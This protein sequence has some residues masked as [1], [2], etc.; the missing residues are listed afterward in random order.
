MP[1]HH[2]SHS[3]H[4]SQTA[5]TLTAKPCVAN[6]N[7]PN[8]ANQICQLQTHSGTSSSGTVKL[9]DM[10]CQAAAPQSRRMSCDMMLAQEKQYQYTQFGNAL[11][12]IH[13]ASW[14]KDISGRLPI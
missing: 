2:A 8:L 12:R 5:E 6:P 11:G 13:E 14:Q 4:N 9:R 7:L 1:C 10:V 3:P